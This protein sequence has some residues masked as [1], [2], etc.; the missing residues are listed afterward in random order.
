M[1][2][3]PHNPP[4]PSAQQPGPASSRGRSLARQRAAD[5][6]LLNPAFMSKLDQLEIVSRK[7]F[8]GRMK[9]ERRSKRKGQSVE[10]ADYRNYVV[11]DD[12]RFLDWNVYA[13]LE[14][15]LIK[16]FMEE[17][18]LNVSLLVDVSSSMD[19]GDPHKG[20]YAKRVAAAAAYI[21]LVNYD[22]VSLY[23][24][25]SGL[26]K[27]MVGVRGRRMTG[28]VIDFLDTLPVDGASS[29]AE[30]ARRYALRHRGGGVCIVVSD[31]LD[32]DGYEAGFR[33][34]LGRRLDVYA[35]HVLS[36]QELEPP[37]AGD[38]KLRDV[39]DGEIAEVTIS[40]PLLDKYKE[41]LAAFCIS[42][43][44]HCTARGVT[45]MFAS[46]RTPFETLVLTYLRQRGLV[47]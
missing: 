28:Q 35:I 17:E 44:D 47:R 34:L 18:D 6:P 5:E 38:L 9:G 22:R 13:R 11:G 23:A 32:K 15:L 46:T 27:E 8:A 14:S 30:G 40:K 3:D 45:Y 39:E 1:A 26:V 2:T 24:Y 10:F 7:I 25:T 29:F 41:T 37:L 4:A 42:L 19:W 31:F 12:L 36:P 21:A 20:L 33:Y 43:K 16:L